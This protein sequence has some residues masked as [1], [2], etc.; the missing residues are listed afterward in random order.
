MTPITEPLTDEE[1]ERACAVF[2]DRLSGQSPQ[3]L[4]RIVLEDFLSRRTARS[5]GEWRDIKDAP[6]TGAVLLCLGETIP[7]LV[8][9]RVGTFISGAEAEELGH[10]EFAKYGGWIIWNSDTDWFV[11]DVDEPT[12]YALLPEPQK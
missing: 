6:K 5:Q 10:R 11:I 4:M 12:R 1:V 9:A 2:S 3:S 8:D 7:D